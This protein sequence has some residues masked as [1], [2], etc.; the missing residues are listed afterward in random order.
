MQKLIQVSTASAILKHQPSISTGLKRL[1]R[2]PACIYYYYF[3]F[4]YP[5]KN[6][7]QL[8][9]T[10][11]NLSVGKMEFALTTDDA[12]TEYRIVSTD[13]MNKLVPIIMANPS[14]LQQRH[15]VPQ[16]RHRQQLL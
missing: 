5:P 14:R 8:T 7:L 11:G 16:Q 6:F 13:L 9:A 3:F 12:A 15:E 10:T 2:T 4:T 1:Q